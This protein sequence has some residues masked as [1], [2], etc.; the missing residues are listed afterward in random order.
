MYH[1]SVLPPKKH[2]NPLIVSCQ[3]S[4]ANVSPK[5]TDAHMYRPTS[6]VIFIKQFQFNWLYFYFGIRFIHFL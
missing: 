6:D 2:K 5:L 1:L 4:I 3:I